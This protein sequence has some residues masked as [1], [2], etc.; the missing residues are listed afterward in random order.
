MTAYDPALAE[1][2][3]A[4]LL[5]DADVTIDEASF[6]WTSGKAR[7]AGEQLLAAAAAADIM[8]GVMERAAAERDALRAE[9]E[10]LKVCL[11]TANDNHER[12]E[13][14]W[15]LTQDERDALR[16][17]VEKLRNRVLVPLTEREVQAALHE[18]RAEAMAA[19]GDNAWTSLL[20]QRD[21]ARIEAI[22]ARAE[23]DALHASLDICHGECKTLREEL[24]AAEDACD[25][26]V[27]MRDSCLARLTALAND[28][29]AAPIVNDEVRPEL[30][31]LVNDARSQVARMVLDTIRAF[32]TEGT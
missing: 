26:A 21:A 28:T 29:I 17:E 27:A 4:E 14:L 20:A 2:L 9:V 19:T 23:R 12:F 25:V 24:T 10:R 8:Q 30:L 15:Y 32:K 1:Q 11:A 18:G 13:R 16:A 5:E 31:A 6:V 22:R 3:A 7:A